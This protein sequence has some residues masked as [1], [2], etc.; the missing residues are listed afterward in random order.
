MKSYF[1]I[2]VLYSKLLYI[3]VFQVAFFIHRVLGNLYSYLFFAQFTLA[4]FRVINCIK[5]DCNLVTFLFIFIICLFDTVSIFTLVYSLTLI[6][7]WYT[8]FLF[9]SF[10]NILQLLSIAFI[11]LFFLRRNSLFFGISS[12]NSYK[13]YV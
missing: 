8:Y 11:H 6:T 5:R 2:L 3:Y 12:L 4:H 1:H 13:R 9:Y 7:F 10:D